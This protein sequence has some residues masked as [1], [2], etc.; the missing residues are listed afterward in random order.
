[1]PRG[2]S[3]FPGRRTP[4]QQQYEMDAH[5]ALL[6]QR[7]IPGMSLRDLV[8]VMDRNED[9]TGTYSAY[10]PYDRYPMLR[11]VTEFLGWDQAYERDRSFSRDSLDAATR[12]IEEKIAARH[13]PYRA[14]MDST[15]K[16]NK[17]KAKAKK[18]K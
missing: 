3:F 6:Q 5:R 9:P 7:G 10:A 8:G 2:K 17:A 13:A 11:P 12:Q 16:A 1:M 14:K 4:E 18:K 15:Y